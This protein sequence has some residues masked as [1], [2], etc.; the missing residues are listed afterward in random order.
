MEDDTNCRF[1]GRLLRV[2][3]AA[4]PLAILEVRSLSGLAWRERTWL[5]RAEGRDSLWAAVADR[6]ERALPVAAADTSGTAEAAGFRLLAG[7]LA[8]T[9]AEI[10]A[11]SPASALLP[12]EKLH[13]MLALRRDGWR[14]H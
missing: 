1:G 11:A 8:S 12:A 14:K 7:Y 9:K 6:P 10:A 13:A 5:L 2:P 4:M 3:A